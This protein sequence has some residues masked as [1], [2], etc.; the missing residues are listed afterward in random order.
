MKVLNHLGES[1]GYVERSKSLEVSKFVSDNLIVSNKIISDPK[2]N[3]QKCII[4]LVYSLTDRTNAVSRSEHTD[5][6]VL[7]APKM[8]YLMEQLQLTQEYICS[9]RDNTWSKDYLDDSLWK[10]VRDSKERAK[11]KDKSDTTHCNGFTLHYEAGFRKGGSESK[12]Y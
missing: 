4:V 7:R 8:E 12:R 3:M 6:L 1:I 11:S 5:K 10:M 9:K 2:D